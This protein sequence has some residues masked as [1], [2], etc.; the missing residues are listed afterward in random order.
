MLA[1]RSLKREMGEVV[2]LDLLSVA[3]DPVLSLKDRHNSSDR[4]SWVYQPRVYRSLEVF[5]AD[6]LGDRGPC[7]SEPKLPGDPYRFRFSDG[8]CVSLRINCPEP[9]DPDVIKVEKITRVVEWMKYFSANTSIPMPHILSSS[10]DVS[11]VLPILGVPFYLVETVKRGKSLH[12]YL[13]ALRE[14]ETVS[15]SRANEVRSNI[16]EQ[17][18][19][20]YLELRRLT[21]DRIGSMSADS[22][23]KWEVTKRPFTGSME[24]LLS[25]IPDCPM[26]EWP[27][28]PFSS[29]EDYFWFMC[30]QNMTALWGLRSLGV[31]RRLDPVADDVSPHWEDDEFN[32]DPEKVAKCARLRFRAR[33]GFLQL[34]KEL[35]TEEGY[36]NGPF[37]PAM[38]HLDWELFRVI[39][40]QRTK[41]INYL[42]EPR[43]INFMPLPFLCIP[44]P[45]LTLKPVMSYIDRNKFDSFIEQYEKELPMFLEAMRTVE[46]RLADT[47]TILKGEKPLSTLMLESWENKRFW[48][49]YA[50]ENIQAVDQLYYAVLYQ[51]H[52]N[53]KP[54]ELSP[55]LEVEM[56][57]YVEHSMEQIYA[58]RKD[59]D[60][61][62]KEVK[63]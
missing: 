15:A 25:D 46:K 36:S 50:L 29:A 11:D 49:H 59:Y 60:N 10:R 30:E 57:K 3:F 40:D 52:P 61:F 53:G 8:F 41:K 55:A 42:F 51:L 23:G 63:D 20:Y 62:L 58:C 45:W 39:Y 7:T 34:I 17:I 1:P 24:Y 5:V 54:F 37:V 56:E 27:E 47:N 31:P 44:P 4:E 9:S 2:P 12:S 33:H 22:S 28:E 38:P 21:M 19:Q 16:Y 6:R 14:S 35:A 32:F 48:F 18:S 26:H 13:T 43:T